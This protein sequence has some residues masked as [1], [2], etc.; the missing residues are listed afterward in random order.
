MDAGLDNG[1]VLMP[2]TNGQDKESEASYDTGGSTWSE[3]WPASLNSCA[4]RPK[5]AKNAHKNAHIQRHV[6]I[7]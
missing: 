4:S 2:E 7:D 6:R 5:F 1:G 3:H